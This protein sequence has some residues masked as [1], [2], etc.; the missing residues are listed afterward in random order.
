MLPASLASACC[1][2][3]CIAA[4]AAVEARAR[5][6]LQ[7]ADVPDPGHLVDGMARG[8][9]RAAGCI[10]RDDKSG[11]LARCR[12]CSR[13]SGCPTEG[14]QRRSLAVVSPGISGQTTAGMRAPMLE[15]W[16]NPNRLSEKSAWAGG[17]WIRRRVLVHL[18]WPWARAQEGQLEGPTL[19]WWCQ[20]F[21]L[22]YPL[23]PFLQRAG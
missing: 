10:G 4:E 11:P 8:I 7:S 6:G 2:P 12:S 18:R 19:L 20:A 16:P 23:L 15:K 5:C 14:R 22:P 3:V 9:S 13:R 21:S 1:P 17:L